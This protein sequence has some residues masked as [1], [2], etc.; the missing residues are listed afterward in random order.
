[1]VDDSF[2]DSGSLRTLRFYLS[3]CR[4]NETADYLIEARLTLYSVLADKRK[5]KLYC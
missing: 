4:N 5:T 2:E 1:M 3:L